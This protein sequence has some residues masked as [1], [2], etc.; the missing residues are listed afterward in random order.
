MRRHWDDDMVRC[1]TCDELMDAA[2]MGENGDCL[3]CEENA[4]D[5][6]SLRSDYRHSVL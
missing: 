2:E 6:D 3:E 4:R 1:D 5:R